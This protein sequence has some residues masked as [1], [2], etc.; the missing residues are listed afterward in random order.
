M[1]SKLRINLSHKSERVQ[2]SGTSPLNYPTVMHS[3]LSPW[4]VNAEV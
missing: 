4:V 1:T 3:H 2:F